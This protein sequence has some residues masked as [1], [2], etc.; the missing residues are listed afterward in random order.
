VAKASGALELLLESSHFAVP[1]DLPTL[2]AES[3]HVMG[4]VDALIHLV[5]LDQRVLVGLD[6]KNDEPGLP[7]DGS[8][9]G[10]AFRQL[11]VIRSTEDATF[12]LWVPMLD[13]TERLGVLKLEFPFDVADDALGEIV[14]FAGLVAELVMVKGAYG[15]YFEVSRRREPVTV[16]ADLLWQL[17]PPLTF[18]TKD[19]VISAMFLPTASLGGDAF[20]YGV[21][22]DTARV[23]IFDAVGHDLGAGLIAT[24]AVAA[25]RNSR[26]DRLGLHDTAQRIG[27][28]IEAHFDPSV[29]ATGIL[30][31]L[32]IATG[33]VSWCIAGHPPPLL[34]RGGKVVKVLD[35]MRGMPF[36]I[37]PASAIG[38]EPLEPG[39]RVLLY[40]D[41]LTEARDERGGFFGIDKL[42]DLLGRTSNTAPP[43][44]MMRRLMHA[45]AEHN[46]GPLRDDATA[47]MIEWRGRG[48][49]DLSV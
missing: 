44:E 34:L 9:A 5:D 39:D 27:A 35:T 48:P 15:D 32:S 28:S 6:A 23:A 3:A 7:I 29:F 10:R 4:A 49:A 24:T 31:S 8:L 46:A 17:L 33:T 36:G 20:D 12:V 19:L 1:D 14:A 2:V 41:G 45:V 40:S 11:E 42:A 21:D 26:R 38:Q 18:G 22:A 13:G 30:V 43:P 37:G 16:G 25:Y 47:V